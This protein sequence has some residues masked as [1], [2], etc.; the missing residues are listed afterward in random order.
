MNNSENNVIVSTPKPSSMVP[1]DKKV[2]QNN[3]VQK[4]A[5]LHPSLIHNTQINGSRDVIQSSTSLD[6]H[7]M[8]NESYTPERLEQLKQMPYKTL[9]TPHELPSKYL[10]S[11]E[12]KN[13]TENQIANSSGSTISES[14]FFKT[15]SVADYQSTLHSKNL[16]SFQ[17]NS[18]DVPYPDR[19][20]FSKALEDMSTKFRNSEISLKDIHEHLTKNPLNNISLSS[21]IFVPAEE[22]RDKILAHE[23]SWRR[24]K[25]IPVSNGQSKFSIASDDHTEKDSMLNFFRNK[26]PDMTD[27]FAKGSPERKGD[28]EPLIF[29]ESYL[30][31]CPVRE[32]DCTNE[33][34]NKKDDKSEILTISQ[35]KKV[36]SNSQFDSPKCLDY[37]AMK[38]PRPVK[39]SNETK[40]YGNSSMFLD[41]QEFEPPHYSTFAEQE[42]NMNKNEVQKDYDSIGAI[43]T[44]EKEFSSVV[45]SVNRMSFMKGGSDYSKNLIT[46]QNTVT[47]VSNN[48]QPST[49][50]NCSEN[51]ENIQLPV[52]HIEVNRKPSTPETHADKSISSVHTG[53]SLETLISGKI[54]VEATKSELIW[55]CVKVGKSGVQKFVL[56]NKINKKIR[57][58]ISVTNSAFKIANTTT[59]LMFSMTVLLHSLETKSFTI[60]FSPTTTGVHVD[61][62]MFSPVGT[63]ADQQQFKQYIKLYGYGGHSAIELTNTSKDPSGRAWLSLGFFDYRLSLVKDV[64]I[65][66]HGSLPAFCYTT[67]IPK[68]HYKFSNITVTPS[69][70]ILFP[71]DEAKVTIQ[72]TYTKEDHKEQHIF[73]DVLEI[74]CLKMVTGDEPTR[75]RIKRLCRKAKQNKLPLDNVIEELGTAFSNEVRISGLEKITESVGALNEL[76]HQLIFREIILTLEK[77]PEKTILATIDDTSTFETLCLNGSNDTFECTMTKK[78]TKCF[79]VEPSNIILTPP[80]K[81]ID[82]ILLCSSSVKPL[83]YKIIVEPSHQIEVQPASGGICNETILIKIFCRNKLTYDSFRVKVY[84]EDEVIEVPVKVMYICK[85]S[86]E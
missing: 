86:F 56:R 54:P 4:L 27:I 51:K 33:T 80:I 7:L 58:Q 31:E 46:K 69:K 83:Q 82:T 26:N 72:L 50:Y 43:N 10:K 76:S 79:S 70:L 45:N 37:F 49:Y 68:Y 39:K 8:R 6:Q 28:P 16:T 41:R 14:D 15:R 29:E 61:K 55:G 18:L 13:V 53:S 19:L 22:A 75:A 11:S 74:G 30:S 67:F 20:S 21:D 40:N 73:V 17:D 52:N 77:D 24:T 9:Q 78:D 65:K 32:S 84:I 42:G 38:G 81:E 25:D 36:L 1:M 59:D 3:F 35:I 34:L 63:I 60:V 71:N 48:A 62:L 2:N 47:V 66:N 64:I 44:F 23:L 57:F 12:A 85:S 5:Q